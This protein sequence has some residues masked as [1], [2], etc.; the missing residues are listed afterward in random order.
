MVHAASRLK[1]LNTAFDTP[2]YDPST[3]LDATPLVLPYLDASLP[4]LSKMQSLGRSGWTGH[5]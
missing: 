3:M 4:L 1:L 2:L 5:R